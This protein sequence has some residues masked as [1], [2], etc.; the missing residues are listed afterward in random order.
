MSRE[1]KFR[2][3]DEARDKM[4][5]GNGLS[6][7]K[8]EDYDDM[9]GFRFEHEERECGERIIEQFTGL[10]DFNGTE[11]YEGDILQDVDNG[12][13]V[14]FVEYDDGFGEY[15][16]GDNNLYECTRDCQVVG[17]IHQNMDLFEEK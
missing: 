12:N 14:G 2:E 1:I 11:I 6:Y 3:W 17:N 16:C 5:Y 4:P 7:G 15:D 10:K 8:R 13:I 9:I